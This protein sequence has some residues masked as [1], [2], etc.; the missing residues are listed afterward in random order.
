MGEEKE[1]Y[2]TAT[3]LQHNIIVQEEGMLMAGYSP[4]ITIQA[5]VQSVRVV[6]ILEASNAGVV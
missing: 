6:T 1:T 2:P 4:S 5:N 3:N